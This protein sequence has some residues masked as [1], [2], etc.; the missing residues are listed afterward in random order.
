MCCGASPKDGIRVHVDHIKPRRDFPELALTFDNLQ[1]LCEVC[2][3]GKGNWDQT[4]WRVPGEPKFAQSAK[5]KSK[6]VP[7]L[8]RPQGEPVA[9]D[10]VMYEPFW[11]MTS[12]KYKLH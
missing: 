6:P 4:D 10:P 1:V 7:R 5:P 9:Q 2:N 12:D 8:V 3:H 11:N